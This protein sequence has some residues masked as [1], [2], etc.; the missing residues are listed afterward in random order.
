MDFCTAIS[1][2]AFHR[3][4]SLFFEGVCF[5]TVDAENTC[6]VV[7]GATAILLDDD[8]TVVR[9]IAFQAIEK[10]LNDTRF[11]DSFTDSV[12]KAS[13][14]A[15]LR[16]ALVEMYDEDDGDDPILS[17]MTA[18]MAAAAATVS[19]VVASIVCYWFVR[20]DGRRHP[21][22]RVSHKGWSPKTNARR[23]VPQSLGG[24]STRRHF[25]RLDDPGTPPSPI[26]TASLT[27]PG[28]DCVPTITWSVSDIT[29]D[30][31]SLRSGMSG[32]P[33]VLARI[34][35]EEEWLEAERYDCDGSDGEESD[36]KYRGD[37]DEDNF[38]SY[39][40]VYGGDYHGYDVGMYG[41]EYE[42]DSHGH[43]DDD[44]GVVDPNSEKSS[45]GT[46][47]QD[48]ASKTFAEGENRDRDGECATVGQHI[49]NFDC[50]IQIQDMVLDV[51]DLDGISSSR[52]ESHHDEECDGY[53]E[54]DGEVDAESDVHGDRFVETASD[55]EISSD[56]SHS[57]E[58]QGTDGV[59]AADILLSLCGEMGVE[60]HKA[61]LHLSDD[62]I[63]AGDIGIDKVQRQVSNR[64]IETRAITNREMTK[65]PPWVTSV[66]TDS[67]SDVSRGQDVDDD[68]S[69][70]TNREVKNSKSRALAAGSIN[71]ATISSPSRHSFSS[72]I[73]DDDNHEDSIEEWVSELLEE[74]A[75]D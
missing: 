20:R 41:E 54:G 25:V 9:L 37:H 11:L 57:L 7:T 16:T 29:S 4:V 72:I 10:G 67:S 32:T 48:T 66:V 31:A 45:Q 43:L 70:G 13:F 14:I 34:E 74:P 73:S 46:F 69:V 56:G 12:V 33:S 63:L 2:H 40:D 23:V 75:N 47:R 35:E 61:M 64:K 19:F 15:P 65:L 51:S 42:E 28:V 53:N 8:S 39:D 62:Q 44:V 22:P 58:T 27:P 68:G 18:A 52:G 24:L 71:H 5:P 59:L 21:E 6:V 3:V 49:E 36:E 26:G 1:E 17:P 30:S 38:A 60:C 55:L 50:E